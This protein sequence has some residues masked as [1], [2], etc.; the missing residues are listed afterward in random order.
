VEAG[1][2]A[3]EEQEVGMV[4]GQGVEGVDGAF[5]LVGRVLG[6]ELEVEGLALHAPQAAQ[7]PGGGAHLLDGFV[8][9]RVAGTDTPDMALE[10][11][12]E[13]VVGFVGENDG[14]GKQSVAERVLRGAASAFR[15]RGAAGARAVGAGSGLLCGCGLPHVTPVHSVNPRTAES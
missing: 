8:L 15:C 6:G 3:V 2:V 9:D 7:A 13:S 1:F 4:A 11:F 12:L 10:H 5:Q 14:A